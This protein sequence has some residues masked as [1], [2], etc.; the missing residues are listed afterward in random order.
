MKHVCDWI[1]KRNDLYHLEKIEQ[2]G[3]KWILHAELK[4]MR[5]G[6]LLGTQRAFGMLEKHIRQP[7]KWLK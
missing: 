4:G 6:S 1:K 3:M 7:R 5:N 2:V